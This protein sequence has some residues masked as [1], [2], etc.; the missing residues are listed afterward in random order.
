MF[1]WFEKL[2]QICLPI[3][4]CDRVVTITNQLITLCP[5]RLEFSTVS[6]ICSMVSVEEFLHFIFHIPKCQSGSNL[7][8]P[9]I[10]MEY[11]NVQCKPTITLH[12]PFHNTT[13][14]LFCPP[15]LSKCTQTSF[16]PYPY[17]LK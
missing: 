5:L 17:V 11:S 14:F 15:Q 7:V 12:M 1:K 8:C 2:F 10:I 9:A 13:L 4:K 6:A 16:S 3:M